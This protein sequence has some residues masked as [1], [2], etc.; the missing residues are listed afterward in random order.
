VTEKTRVRV[1]IEPDVVREIDDAEL[2]DLQ[3][4]GLIH[5]YEHTD[6]AAEVLPAGFKAPNRWRAPDKSTEIIEAPA[7]V[8]DTMKGE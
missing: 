5:S 6:H 4:Q 8:T 1:T 7:P 2:V 3:R